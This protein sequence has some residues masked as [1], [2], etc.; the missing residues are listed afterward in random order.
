MNKYEFQ[1]KAVSEIVKQVNEGN[2]R[3]LLRSPTGTGKSKM[4]L[5][6]RK[7]LGARKTIVIL[8]SP[9][10]LKDFLTKIGKMPDNVKQIYDVGVLNGLYTVKT[11]KN[12]LSRGLELPHVSYVLIDEAHH[13]VAD[14]YKTI[15]DGLEEDITIIG[16]TATNYCGN[17]KDTRNFQAIWK[18][19][20]T[21]IT[22]KEAVELGIISFPKVIVEPLVDDDLIKVTSTGE[23][24]I[25]T[26]QAH[27]EDKLE[28]AFDLLFNK[29]NWFELDET[30]EKYVPKRPTLI[31]VPSSSFIDAIEREAIKRKLTVLPL[32]ADT[33][34]AER[35]YIY[36]SITE[37][38]A[39]GLH[40][41]IIS[42]GKD[43]PIRNILDLRPVNSPRFFVQ[44]FG[45]AT[46]PL[47][48]HELHLGPGEYVCTNRNIERHSYLFEGVLPY[49]TAA[50][51]QLAFENPSERGGKRIIGIESLGKIKPFYVMTTD[52]CKIA[53][54]TVS[55]NQTF[56]AAILHPMHAMPI[57]FVKKNQLADLGEGVM[58]K[59][60][61][62][63]SMCKPPVNLTGH[64][65]IQDGPLTEAQYRRWTNYAHRHGLDK[66][67]PVKRRVFEVLNILINCQLTMGEPK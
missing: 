9:E 37:C 42:E 57:W 67:Q 59:S 29:F 54:Y 58:Q 49:T 47:G 25:E 27:T 34:S 36:N 14:E 24:E 61:G 28:Y 2:N 19:T 12:K 21:A 35:E 32:F 30:G 26:L 51:A 16:Y 46:R 15:I 22:L 4:I 8:S 40:A 64:R 44:N 63:W 48:E 23:F 65:S 60:Y 56:Y 5:D 1:E 7:A 53:V 50:A 66:D 20:I 6:T 10:I 38:R 45:R 17:G 33:P 52:G 39:V 43:L 62:M 18:K 55:F 11:L 31:C 3:V 13:M 41:N